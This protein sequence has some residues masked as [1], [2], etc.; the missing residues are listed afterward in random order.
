MPGP[1]S[2]QSRV[3][4]SSSDWTRLPQSLTHN[5]RPLQGQQRQQRIS[6]DRKAAILRGLPQAVL[7]EAVSAMAQA[8]FGLP[9]HAAR[10]CSDTRE[11]IFPRRAGD[12]YRGKANRTGPLWRSRRSLAA[13]LANRAEFRQSSAPLCQGS[14]LSGNAEAGD[15][16][17]RTH[18]G[19]QFEVTPEYQE[20]DHIFERAVRRAQG[21]AARD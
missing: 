11:K 6:A 21:N 16:V 17:M 12:V 2:W 5:L 20:V 7:R 4:G 1:R 13:D 8:W 15:A 14:L 18:N 3:Q 9:A 19:G 10:G